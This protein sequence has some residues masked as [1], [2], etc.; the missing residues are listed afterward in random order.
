[1]IS[2][3]D[4]QSVGLIRG[5]IE[6]MREQVSQTENLI[7]GAE[8]L[9]VVLETD[10]SEK[11]ITPSEAASELGLVKNTVIA[12]IKKGNIKAHRVD[13]EYRIAKSEIQRIKEGRITD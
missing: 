9:I 7:K 12:Q 2:E 6:G 8:R 11:Y 3:K 5:M 4:K 13:R 10:N 1:M